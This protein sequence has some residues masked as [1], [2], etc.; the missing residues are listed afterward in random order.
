VAAEES[1]VSRVQK[2]LALALNNSNPAE[3]ELAM[4][5]ARELMVKHAVEEWQLAGKKTELDV[6]IVKI[7]IGRRFEGWMKIVQ[8]AVTQ[9]YDGK[10]YVGTRG[11]ADVATIVLAKSDVELFQTSYAF[12]VKTILREAAK[13][14]HGKTVASSFRMGAAV[15]LLDA[16]EKVKAAERNAPPKGK[17]GAEST[18]LVLVRKDSIAKAAKE[19]FPKTR[20]MSIAVNA[21]DRASYA[22]GYNLGATLGT[23]E[24]KKIDGE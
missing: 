24:R 16:V 8:I 7:D 9:M 6:D 4:T 5:K 22:A 18:A 15:G 13:I 17:A 23:P 2:L 1:I 14:T 20:A 12:V 10:N 21:A 19:M 11:G 3:A